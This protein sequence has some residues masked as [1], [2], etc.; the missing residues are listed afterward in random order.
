MAKQMEEVAIKN[1]SLAFL[2]H[3]VRNNYETI[4]NILIEKP[5]HCQIF[6]MAIIR[7]L[8]EHAKTKELCLHLNKLKLNPFIDLFSTIL[9]KKKTKK[10]VKAIKA[11]EK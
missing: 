9:E 4:V 11:E 6:C 3:F 8:Q 10:M 7:W 2:E 1:M 5:F